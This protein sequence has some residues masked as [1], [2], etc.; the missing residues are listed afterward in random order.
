MNQGKVD[1]NSISLRYGIGVTSKQCPLKYIC[2]AGEKGRAVLI[3]T[4]SGA[5]IFY[6]DLWK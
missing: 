6:S 1:V 4:E 5:E 3:Y 2:L